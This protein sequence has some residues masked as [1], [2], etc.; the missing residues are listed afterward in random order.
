MEIKPINIQLPKEIENLVEGSVFDNDGLISDDKL[1]KYLA[2]NPE[3]IRIY[4]LAMVDLKKSKRALEL[5]VEKHEKAMERIRASIILKLDPGIYKN[6]GMREA[7][8]VLDQEYQREQE[9]ITEIKEDLIMLSS[10]L[11]ELSEKYWKHK[12]MQGSLDS[13]TKLRLAERKY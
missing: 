8:V 3:I 2:Y 7:K 5:E 12:S 13:M 4:G 9:I 11:D 1:S 10:E 6:D